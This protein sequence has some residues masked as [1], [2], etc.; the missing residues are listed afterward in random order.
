MLR[1]YTGQMEVWKTMANQGLE[2][3]RWPARRRPGVCARPGTELVGCKSPRQ[4]LAEP[5]A[6][7]R[8]RA[9]SRGDVWR[10]PNPNARGDAQAPATRGGAPG[11]RGH[12]TMQ[13]SIRGGGAL[14]QAG[15]YAPKVLC[16]T[17]GALHAVRQRGARREEDPEPT[18]MQRSAEGI[19][20]TS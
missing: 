11:T 13:S 8:A 2:P 9:P 7:S 5:Q 10:K 15:V 20:G 14:Y 3:T 4:V 12:V 17:L 16:L 6:R 18:G 1:H 19:G